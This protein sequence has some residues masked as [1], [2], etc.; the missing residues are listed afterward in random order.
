MTSACCIWLAIAVL[1]H[2][3]DISYVCFVFFLV[4]DNLY[5]LSSWLL[6]NDRIS[7]ISFDHAMSII[8]YLL[9]WQD[10]IICF[11]L[12]MLVCNAFLVFFGGDYVL[13]ID[14][15]LCLFLLHSSHRLASLASLRIA[16]L[17]PMQITRANNSLVCLLAGYPL[18]RNW[19]GTKGPNWAP[20]WLF[21]P[22]VTKT[23][24]QWAAS[25]LRASGLIWHFGAER[26]L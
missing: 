24:P 25:A 17:P 5:S 9:L 20:M 12:Q 22:S 3:G 8:S 15:L 23:A 16:A 7:I 14:S 6:C 13:I 10:G 4:C 19:P 11:L 1:C 26:D 21:S 18:Y 2:F